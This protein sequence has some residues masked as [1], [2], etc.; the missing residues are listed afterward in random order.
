MGSHGCSTVGNTINTSEADT[1]PAVRSF[2]DMIL[3][4]AVGVVGIQVVFRVLFYIAL[5]SFALRF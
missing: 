4:T 1:M 5:N 3:V 2:V